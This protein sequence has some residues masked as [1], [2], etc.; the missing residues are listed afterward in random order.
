MAT[1]LIFQRARVVPVS[2][3]LR[4]CKGHDVSKEARDKA[5]RWAG[6]ATHEDTHEPGSLK[7]REEGQSQDRL[8]RNEEHLKETGDEL[9]HITTIRTPKGHEV[10]DGHHR[11]ISAQRLGKTIRGV[12]I[13]EKDFKKLKSHGFDD[14]D[15][16]YGM[17]KSNGKENAA[18]GMAR[19]FGVTPKMKKMAAIMSGENPLPEKELTDAEKADRDNQIERF[20]DRLPGGEFDKY[21]DDR[22][23]YLKRNFKYVKRRCYI[24]CQH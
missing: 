24:K 19:Q 5:G 4:I 15:I 7:L 10:I 12:S 11:A 22:E 13:S 3:V 14:L 2:E 9:E 6:I 16:S 8:Q 17:L 1:L 18:L 20:V 23:G 21:L